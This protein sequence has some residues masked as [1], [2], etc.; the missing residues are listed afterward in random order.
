MPKLSHF[1]LFVS[2]CMI[3][4]CGV[5]NEIMST[6]ELPPAAND[7]ISMRQ[8]DRIDGF[9]HSLS[10]QTFNGAVVLEKGGELIVGNGY[11]YALNSE[12]LPF[13]TKTVSNT[14]Q[15]ARQFTAAA[16]LKL[17][18]KQ[19]LKLTDSLSRFFDD[20]PAD[21]RGIQLIHLLK[22]TSGLPLD[23]REPE[24]IR[25]KESFLD[26][27]R[28]LPL[29][30]VPGREYHYSEVAYRL[31]AAV[32]EAAS[33][34]DYELFL[35][36]ELFEPAGM[37]NTGYSLPDFQL[38]PQAKSN[39]ANQD[40]EVLYL[41][42]KKDARFLWHIMG[43]RGMLSNSEDLFRWM[44]M[45]LKGG[46]LPAD[47]LELL[48][49]ASSSLPGEN[50]AFGWAETSGPGGAPV[51]MHQSSGNGFFAQLL[52]FPK[53]EVSLVLLANQ[54]NGQVLNLGEQLL[55]VVVFPNYVPSPLPYTEQKLVRLPQEEEARH[56]RALLQ[57]IQE[58]DLRAAKK[59]VNEHYTAGFRANVL[60]QKHLEALE[61]LRLQLGH[62]NLEK[63]EQNLPFFL[64]TFSSPTGLWY[65][66]RV[67]VEPQ[68]AFQ[69]NT[70]SLE[71]TDALN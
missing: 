39:L 64:F 18:A 29:I 46:L 53:E 30:A 69:I 16:I 42:Y 2:W 9:L 10:P 59:L 34:L 26:A 28:S 19:K 7:T 14:A 56:V 12:K 54:V 66:L 50:T 71:T 40:E 51:L 20:L 63:A 68:Q 43:S 13:T 57:F 52:Y 17:E 3:A 4:S 49:N 22:N 15:L 70:I 65:Q 55:K 48:G 62:S 45:L 32:V 60:E 47:A 37:Y 21:K 44:H 24:S 25:S 35:R 41:Q 11:G 67:Q 27:V 1:I 58:G 31:L 23:F 61:K 6:I 38:I 36:Q 8:A 33:G 5:Q